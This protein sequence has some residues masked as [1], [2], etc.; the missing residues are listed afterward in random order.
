MIDF[1]YKKSAKKKI[2]IVD[3]T[4]IMV[5]NIKNILGD[6]YT[7]FYATSGEQALHIIPEKEPDLILLDYKMPGMD[8]KQ[9]YEEML[10]DEDMKDIPVIF[11][12]STADEKT[13]LSILSTK[14]A[15]YILKPANQ[16]DLLE[17]I[18]TC[19]KNAEK[20]KKK[21]KIVMSRKS[22]LFPLSRLLIPC[23][24]SVH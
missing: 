14:P 6:K 9:V 20:A 13:I 8:G 4:A 3:D 2:M 5:R 22:L 23:N 16:A 7:V 15:G 18:S 17:K 19:L 21:I 1:N 12:T 24:V 11:L 10:K